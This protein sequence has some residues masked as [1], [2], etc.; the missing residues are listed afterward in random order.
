MPTE[1]PTKLP[2]TSPTLAPT[3]PTVSPTK[4][5][6]RAPTARPTQA[7][8]LPPAYLWVAAQSTNQIYSCSVPNPVRVLQLIEWGENLTW[9]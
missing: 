5:P 9:F 8:T 4:Q 6:S 2:T 1:Q 3:A 7:P